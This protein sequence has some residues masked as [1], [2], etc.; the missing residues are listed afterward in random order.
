MGIYLIQTICIN[1]VKPTGR[2]LIFFMAIIIIKINLP[3]VFFYNNFLCYIIIKIWYVKWE[4]E[5]ENTTVSESK[6]VAFLPEMLGTGNI[7]KIKY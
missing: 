4:F 6:L 2:F 7:N 1:C 3:Y 5:D